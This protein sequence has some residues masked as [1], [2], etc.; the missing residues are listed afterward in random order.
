MISSGIVEEAGWCFFSITTMLSQGRPLVDN[1]T[2]V[3]LGL[4]S[5]LTLMPLLHVPRPPS[6][7]NLQRQVERG[8]DI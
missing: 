1:T 6:A 7:L 3:F 8:G 4:T 2:L 5:F